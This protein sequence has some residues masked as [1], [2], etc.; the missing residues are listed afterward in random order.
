VTPKEIAQGGLIYRTLAGSRLYGIHGPDSDYDY[1]GACIEPFSEVLLGDFEQWVKS[2]KTE[3]IYSLRKLCRL[4]LKGNPT[5]T[6]L[7]WAPERFWTTHTKVGHE[8]RDM[9][10]LFL[11]KRTIRAFLGYL[12]EQRMRLNGERG[13]KNIKRIALVE[14]HGYDTKYASHIVRLAIMATV[15]GRTNRIVVPLDDKHRAIIGAIRAGEWALEDVLQLASNHE[16]E[17]EKLITA[18]SLPDEPNTTEVE[19]WLIRV[20]EQ[21]WDSERAGGRLPLGTPRE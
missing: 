9:R 8:L 18:S 5:V 11:S 17:I 2:D 6:E 14:K 21:H 19:A 4:M 12:R 20:Y 10:E 3:T 15:L 13:Q 16:K 1:L 7:L